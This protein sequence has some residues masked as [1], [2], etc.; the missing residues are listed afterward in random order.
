M[1]Q[2][3]AFVGATGMIGLPVA[4]ALAAKDFHVT[5]LVRYPEKARKLLPASVTFIQGDLRNKQDIEKLLQGNPILYLNLNLKQ[6]ERPSDFHA[7]AEGLQ[8][9]LEVAKRE[10]IQRIAFVSSLVMNYQGMNGFN[11]WVF[12]IKHSAVQMIKA[13]GIPYTIFYLSTLM[14][15]FHGNYRMGNRLLLAGTSLHKM[16]FFSALDFSK[17][18]VRSFEFLNNEN[19]EYTIQGLEGFTADE[20]AREFQRY[21]T[22]EKLHIATAPLGILK[23]F[24]RFSQKL[25]YGVNIIEALNNY[26]E[27]FGAEKTWQEL[28]KPTITLRDFAQF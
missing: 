26:P 11:W 27:K 25:N 21:Y 5:A 10:G 4:K 24:G 12:D 20:A 14:E 1:S 23:F 13:S 3:I 15:N 22:K 2:K 6:N 16:H 9:V 17:Q 8:N 7:E 18:V 19:K 28:G